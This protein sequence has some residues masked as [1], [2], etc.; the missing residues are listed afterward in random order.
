MKKNIKI[1][2]LSI[3]LIFISYYFWQSRQNNLITE[4][5]QNNKDTLHL[6]NEQKKEIQIKIAI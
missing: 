1:L 2:F 5:Q 3:L 4:E 6:T